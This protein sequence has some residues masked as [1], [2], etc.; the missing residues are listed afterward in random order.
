[1]EKLE[2]YDF[3]KQFKEHSNIVETKMENEHYQHKD[4]K[5]ILF[6]DYPDVHDGAG[7]LG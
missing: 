6:D 3:I 1:M 2:N 5:A 7:G 4:E